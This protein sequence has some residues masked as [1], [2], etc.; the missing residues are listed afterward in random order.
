VTVADLVADA[1]ALTPSEAAELVVP[2]REEVRARLLRLQQL[3]VQALR[4]RA[5]TA[6][7]GLE[8]LGSR[9]VFTRPIERL[10]ELAR[11]IDELEVRAR[12]AVANRLHT[13]RQ[14][15]AAVGGR[16]EALSPLKT[17][18]RGYS[19]TRL[20]PAGTVV[21]SAAE[22]RPGDS[23][24]TLLQSGRLTSRV[25]AAALG[26]DAAVVIDAGIRKQQDGKTDVTTAD[27]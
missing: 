20:L 25:E 26:T 6:R 3:L 15:L 10:H 27:R 13:S 8:A 18:E 5:A 16:L 7:A 12:R 9:R 14:Q 19:V 22:A 2:D 1:R 11:S 24:E 17:L 21:R 23:L 4:S